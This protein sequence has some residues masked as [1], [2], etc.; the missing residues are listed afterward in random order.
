MWSNPTRVSYGDDDTH[1][2]VTALVHCRVDERFLVDLLGRG[3]IWLRPWFDLPRKRPS[4]WSD[5]HLFLTSHHKRCHMVGS[6]H[7]T[8]IIQE[9]M[10][11]SVQSFT[12]SVT[13]LYCLLWGRSTQGPGSPWG[14][15]CPARLQKADKTQVMHA[16]C[17]FLSDSEDLS[18]LTTSGEKS[19]WDK[20]HWFPR[21]WAGNQ[22]NK[23]DVDFK[24]Q[25]L[26]S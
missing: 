23:R 5:F 1:K 12:L 4:I 8:W 16:P 14:P 24:W 19:C 3:A 21:K 7:L 6:L 25:L 18:L 17:L 20:E 26:G 13:H 22:T 11:N 2:L 15:I 10:Q 9:S